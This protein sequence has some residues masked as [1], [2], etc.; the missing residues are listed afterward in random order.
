MGPWASVG[1]LQNSVRDIADQTLH[2]TY[3][4]MI[5]SLFWWKLPT[6]LDPIPELRLPSLELSTLIIGRD[7][8]SNLRLGLFQNMEH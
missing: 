1:D 4:E 8:I 6:L 2:Y 7:P 3:V 5:S